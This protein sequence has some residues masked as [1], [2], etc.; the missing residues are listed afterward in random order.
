MVVDARDRQQL[1]ERLEATLGECPAEVLMENLFDEGAAGVAD[2]LGAGAGRPRPY[3]AGCACSCEVPT[4]GRWRP[5]RSTL[6]H[7]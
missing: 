5:A 7:V 6:R 3:L 4:R 1:Q 2:R